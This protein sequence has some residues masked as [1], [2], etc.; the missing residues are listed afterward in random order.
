MNKKY[1]FFVLII[2]CYTYPVLSRLQG[3]QA[4]NSVATDTPEQP[5]TLQTILC[6]TSV[7]KLQNSLVAVLDELYDHLHYWQQA[8]FRSFGYFIEKGPYKW[9]FGKKQDDDIQSKIALLEHE[10]TRNA[11]YLG[12]LKE[13]ENQFDSPKFKNDI[14]LAV[15][16]I[17]QCLNFTEIDD[18]TSIS[19]AYQRELLVFRDYQEGIRKYKKRAL[20]LVKTARKPSHVSR[21]W[22]SYSV[23]TISA[24]AGFIYYTKNK[25]KIATWIQDGKQASKNFFTDYI[26]NPAKNSLDIVYRKKEDK[27]LISPDACK[28]DKKI[29]EKE[30]WDY[31]N[32]NYSKMPKEKV[33]ANI[34]EAVQSNTLPSE[35]MNDYTK[36]MKNPTWNALSPRGQIVRLFILAQFQPLKIR[37]NEGFQKFDRLFKANELN[38][39]LLVGLPA[40]L[41]IGL[42]CY[43]SYKC[44]QTCYRF[45]SPQKNL[46]FKPIKK[47]LIALETIFND[48]NGDV[49]K[50]NYTTHGQCYYWLSKL[51]KACYVIPLEERPLFIADLIDLESS[52]FTVS[53]KLA[54]V[55]RMYRAYDFL[56]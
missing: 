40:S 53:Q 51:K 39:E 56:R 34:E 54:T 52:V 33:K 4:I 35:V 31:Y 32:D 11:S 16:T 45:I 48:H 3:N 30:L 25:D 29:L 22:L 41:L 10:I 5:N 17:D 50:M 28:I 8:Q 24:L 2:S 15:A 49:K 37:V 43:S 19:P 55:Q 7:Q 21:H 36:Q 20:R 18:T 26:K 1:A 12:K 38:F 27:P 47:A 46:L 6:K 44:L 14:D 9:L 23:A 13:L 42:A